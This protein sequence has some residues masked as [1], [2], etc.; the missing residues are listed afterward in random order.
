MSSR[1]ILNVP[2]DPFDK[3]LGWLCISYSKSSFELDGKIWNS[4]ETYILAK[5]FEGTILEETI[6]NSKSIVLARSLA[7]QRSVITQNSEGILVKEYRYGNSKDPCFQIREDWRQ[8][9]YISTR[10]AVYAKFF[11]N[12][13]LKQKLASLD[14]IT[15]EDAKYPNHGSAL[16]E[17]KELILDENRKITVIKTPK[18]MPK[19][20]EDMP[21]KKDDIEDIFISEVIRCVV[22]LKKIESLELP[23]PPEIFED[24]IYNVIGTKSDFYKTKKI[25]SSVKK[26]ISVTV[27]SWS[28]VMKEMPQ[29]EK[30]VRHTESKISSWG[31]AT[32]VSSSL[33]SSGDRLGVSILLTSFIRWYRFDSAIFE[34]IPKSLRDFEKIQ[35]KKKVFLPEIRRRYRSSLPQKIIVTKK[36]RSPSRE[37]MDEILERGSIYIEKFSHMLPPEDFSRVVNILE[38]KK[39]DK[40]ILWLSMF[41]SKSQND[42]AAMLSTMLRTEI[43]KSD[44][45]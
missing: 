38:K 41:D 44:I 22:A 20:K 24:A 28:D 18:I 25:L 6:R 40:R 1:V 16:N 32:Q 43:Q 23:L 2:S 26:W 3:K 34:N 36:P 33:V 29:F 4:V 13:K 7:T 31:P 14:G 37:N 42:K 27:V 8:K 39:K 10:E 15:I 21:S 11:Q 19:P 35:K 12:Q 45:K 5:R 9:D 17:I 30:E